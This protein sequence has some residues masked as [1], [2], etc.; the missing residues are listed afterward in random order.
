MYFLLN[1]NNLFLFLTIFN[2]ILFIII[3]YFILLF[4]FSDGFYFSKSDIL[5]VM[6]IFTLFVII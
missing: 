6:L 3:F 5:Y 4:Y 1:S 2:V